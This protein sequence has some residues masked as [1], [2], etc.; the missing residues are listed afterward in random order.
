MIENEAV[1]VPKRTASAGKEIALGVML[2]LVSIA[3]MVIKPSGWQ[4][5]VTA[6][7]L[8]GPAL[9]LFSAA[10]YIV[11]IRNIWRHYVRIQNNSS[12]PAKEKEIGVFLWNDLLLGVSTLCYWVGVTVTNYE[13]GQRNYNILAM[14]GFAV[15]LYIARRLFA[16]V[17]PVI[18]ERGAGYKG[19]LDHWAFGGMLLFAAYQGLS[20]MAGAELVMACG[21]FVLWCQ[22]NGYMYEPER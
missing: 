2:A 17:L 18:T 5:E 21:F 9:L 10:T 13:L 16:H 7:Q 22:D 12:A 6:M 4:V 14:V 15:L 20:P 11:A 19:D 1:E 8:L 3:F